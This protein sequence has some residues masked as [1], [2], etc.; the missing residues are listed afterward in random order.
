MMEGITISQAIEAIK[1]DMK[2]GYLD[3]ADDFVKA[4]RLG[5]EALKLVKT[6]RGRGWYI[7]K[8]LL[9]GETEE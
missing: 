9:P 6:L 2:E 1:A 7:V 8:P 5:L 4:M 3:E